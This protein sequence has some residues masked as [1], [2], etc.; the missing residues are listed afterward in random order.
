MI[1]SR[2][3]HTSSSREPSS[4]FQGREPCLPLPPLVQMEIRLSLQ[5]V[6]ELLRGKDCV[7]PSFIHPSVHPFANNLITTGCLRLQ[8]KVDPLAWPS[9]PVPAFA[10][11]LSSPPLL[12]VPT[13]SAWA[14]LSA[15]VSFKALLGH[16]HP[17]K[18]LLPP[19]GSPHS[20]SSWLCPLHPSCGPAGAAEAPTARAVSPFS[21]SPLANAWHREGAGSVC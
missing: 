7:T 3:Q 16:H 15:D 18:L 10:Y 5:A 17:Q 8:D 20:R 4:Y 9:R 12:R 14:L 11:F 1:P 2:A 19:P 13:P 21:L 6:C